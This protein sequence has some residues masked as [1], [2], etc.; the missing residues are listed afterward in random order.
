M[1]F[2]PSGGDEESQSGNQTAKGDWGFSGIWELRMNCVKNRDFFVVVV[3][4]HFPF[5]VLVYIFIKGIGGNLLRKGYL[6]LAEIGDRTEYLST[7]LSHMS[8]L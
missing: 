7:N 1:L 8:L 6:G 4:L 5:D 2:S 3:A